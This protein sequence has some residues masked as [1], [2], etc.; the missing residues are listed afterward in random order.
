MAGGTSDKDPNFLEQAALYGRSRDGSD[1]AAIPPVPHLM[2][3]ARHSVLSPAPILA[4]QARAEVG[5][6]A[7]LSL[8]AGS[9]ES[10]APQPPQVAAAFAAC[11]VEQEQAPEDVADSWED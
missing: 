10:E 11:V 1:P 3:L 6:V 2:L 8:D 7:A 4:A 9:S 5:V